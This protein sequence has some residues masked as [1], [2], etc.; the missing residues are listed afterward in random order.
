[1]PKKKRTF[2]RTFL[3]GLLII[4][5][6][7]ITYWVMRFIFAQIDQAVTPTIRQAVVWAGFQWLLEE[8]WV[9]YIAPMVSVTLLVLLI[10]AIGLFGGNVLGQQILDGVDKLLRSIPLVRGIYTATRQFVDTFAKEGKSFRKV[11]LVEYPR[12]GLW[13]IALLTGDATGEV[14]Y[15]ADQELV[16]VFVPTTPNPTSGWLLFVPTTDL[17][18]LDMSVDD[19]FKL[20]ISG[21]V[22]TPEFVPKEPHALP[23][24]SNE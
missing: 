21:G 3:T 22:L 6:V 16:S 5:P 19:A 24:A 20:I 15:R 4:L 9:P 13:T 10:Y 11:V 23:R 7:F 14:A 2:K 18:E 1:M 17:V 12:K 8:G